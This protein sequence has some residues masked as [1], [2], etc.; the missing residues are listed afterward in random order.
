MVKMIFIKCF[1]VL[2]TKT[3]LLISYNENQ[4]SLI[5]FSKPCTKFNIPQK[6]TKL[7]PKVQIVDLSGPTGRRL[8]RRLSSNKS[9]DMILTWWHSTRNEVY[10]WSPLVKDED[11]ANVHIYSLIGNKMELLCFYRTEF[12]LVSVKFSRLKPNLIRLIEQKVSKKGDVAIEYSSYEVVKKS[13]KKH[14]AT[15]VPL[16]TQICCHSISPDEEKLVL[17]KKFKMLSP[18][19]HFKILNKIIKIIKMY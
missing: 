6:L 9:G 8:D 19:F 15:S 13:L 3:H 12:D 7:E 5:N 17:G 4:V 1:L 2:S 11:R 18:F 10:P 14:F 16:Q